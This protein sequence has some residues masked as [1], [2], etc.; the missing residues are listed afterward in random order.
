M[1]RL[2]QNVLVQTCMITALHKNGNLSYFLGVETLWKGTV[3]AE[4]SAIRSKLCENCGFPLNSYTRI[5]GEISAFYALLC[6][7]SRY[8][9][10][11][12]FIFFFFH[13]LWIFCL[14]ESFK[15]L[16]ESVAK[17]FLL[18]FNNSIKFEETLFLITCNVKEKAKQLKGRKSMRLESFMTFKIRA[19]NSSAFHVK[20]S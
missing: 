7:S 1:G 11:C 18:T 13:L 16:L 15:S 20:T 8:C 3:S 6:S 9:L 17:Y 2:L 19:K 12:F 5:L 14:I 10:Q 4:L